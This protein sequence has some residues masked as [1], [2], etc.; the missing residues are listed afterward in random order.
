VPSVLILRQVF[1]MKQICAPLP[2]HSPFFLRALITSP[3]SGYTAPLPAGAFPQVNISSV[4]SSVRRILD[5]NCSFSQSLFPPPYRII[6]P[7]SACF[8]GEG[9]LARLGCWVFPAGLPSRR[10]TSC[11]R[12]NLFSGDLPLARCARTEPSPVFSMRRLFSAD[13]LL[14]SDAKL[15]CRR[16]SIPPS[17]RPEE[18]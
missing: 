4:F 5:L 15:S 6:P 14:K 18:I 9:I 1:A 17:F 11:N 8:P 2:R 12:N 3:F 7:I 13:T 10:F 16:T